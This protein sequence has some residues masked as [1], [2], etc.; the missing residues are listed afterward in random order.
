MSVNDTSTLTG[1]ITTG[2]GGTNITFPTERGNAGEFLKMPSSGGT[3]E[4]GTAASS[5]G[6]LTDVTFS[7]GTYPLM[8]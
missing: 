4:F 3:L 8:I 5:I 2:S 7:S 1:A 6:E